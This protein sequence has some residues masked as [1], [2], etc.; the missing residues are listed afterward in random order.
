MRDGS[1]PF[2]L[3]QLNTHGGLGTGHDPADLIKPDV[4]INIILSVAKTVPSFRAATTPGDA[5]AA[6]VTKIERP[7]DQIGAIKDRTAIAGR[8]LV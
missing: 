3:F 4:N 7:A 8:L 5:V 2:G 6:F 1:A